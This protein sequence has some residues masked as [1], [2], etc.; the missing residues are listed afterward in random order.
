MNAIQYTVLHHLKLHPRKAQ[1]N[2]KQ[3]LNIISK[4]M[5]IVIVVIIDLYFTVVTFVGAQKVFS[6]RCTQPKAYFD[7][8]SVLAT[9]RKNFH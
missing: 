7:I 2:F 5:V 1:L 8:N 6:I 9:A 3:K 4:A